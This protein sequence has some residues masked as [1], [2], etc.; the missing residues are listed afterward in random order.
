VSPPPAFVHDLATCVGCHA[1]VV[2]CASENGTGPGASWRQV[3]TFNEGRHPHLPVFHL[4][5]ACNHCLDA[6]CERHCPAL[7]IARDDRTGAV[8]IDADRCIGCRYCSWVCPYDAPRFEAGRGVMGK[9][10]LCH[11]RLLEGGQPACTGA[12]PT[13]ALKLGPFDGEGLR[14]VPGF[15]DAGIRPAIRFLPLRGRAPDPAAEEAAAGAS[16]AGSAEPWPAP[17]RPVSLRSE[18]TLFAFT[19]LVIV[20]LAWLAASLLGGPRVAPMPFLALGLA[21]IAL[22]TLHLGRK[23][24]APLAVRNWRRSWLSREVLAVPSFLALAAAHLLLAPTRPLAGGLAVAAGLLALVCIDRVYAAM[25]RVGRPRGDDAAALSSAAF[26]AG[27][28]A[29]QPWLALAAGLARL[30]AAAE[31]LVVRR[32]PAGPAPW[33]LAVARIGVGLAVPAALLLAAGPAFLPLAAA[34]A[35]VGE[36]V[37]RAH[38]YASLEVVTPRNLMA[39]DL[40]ARLGSGV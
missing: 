40:A 33:A 15:P 7:A 19:S 27:V 18:W 23:E 14:L 25:A 9:C 6:P 21:G 11:H 32:A 24:R 26:L 4:S 10:T 1:C 8:L 3:V 38:F 36:L 16:S 35:L 29:Q 37:D 13:G 39:G 2:A 31:R 30:A 5:L 17:R 22:S 34:A 28:L 12:C 20:L